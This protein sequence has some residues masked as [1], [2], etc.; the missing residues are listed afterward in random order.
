ML[1][2][3]CG[4]LKP[5]DLAQDLDL[6]LRDGIGHAKE[7]LLAN[8]SKDNILLLTCRGGCRRRI[9]VVLGDRRGHRTSIAILSTYQALQAMRQARGG[10]RSDHAAGF[11]SLVG[12]NSG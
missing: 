1:S 3:L 7:F 9:N 11:G 6:P 8:H 4:D 10:T 12:T 5:G 2:A